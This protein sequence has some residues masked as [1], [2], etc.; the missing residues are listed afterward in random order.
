MPVDLTSFVVSEVRVSPI[1]AATTMPPLIVG[2]YTGLDEKE[3]LVFAEGTGSLGSVQFGYFVG[4]L[5]FDD[6]D[7]LWKYSGTP[8]GTGLTATGSSPLLDGVVVNFRAT[9]GEAGSPDLSDR[10]SVT[11]QSFA[12]G[13]ASP[14]DFVNPPILLRSENLVLR[15]NGAPMVLNEDYVLRIADG[16]ILFTSRMSETI[17]SAASAGIK[18]VKTSKD[19][20][21]R[22]NFIY[23]ESLVLKTLDVDYVFT[24]QGL[25][26]LIQIVVSEDLLGN[27]LLLNLETIPYEPLMV[28]KKNGITMRMGDEYIVNE[29]GGWINTSVPLFRG[30][31]LTATY[32]KEDLTLVVDDLIV[33]SPAWVLTQTGPFVF[34]T[35]DV[36]NF[37]V[38]GVTYSVNFP[39]DTYTAETLAVRIN[40]IAAIT[41]AT[42]QSDGTVKIYS[43][44]ANPNLSTLEILSGSANS[45]LGLTVGAY[46]GGVAFGGEDAHQSSVVPFILNTY[47]SVTG[48]TYI[49]FPGIDL[50]SDYGT[51]TLFSVDNDYYVS[52][53]GVPV[54]D[55]TKTRVSVTYS[56]VRDYKSPSSGFVSGVVLFIP[57]SSSY[58]NIP[59]S[60]NKVVFRGVDLTLRYKPNRFIKIGNIVFLVGGSSLVEGNTEVSLVVKT[61]EAIS[62]TAP[63]SYRK[64][65]V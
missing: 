63:V 31:V 15:K 20:I 7:S 47:N 41:V 60:S 50:T 12:A 65:V 26:E 58:E 53:P 13:N 28:V 59:V 54:Y 23:R 10:V 4:E 11:G 39:V 6:K 17:I 55:G 38:Q 62:N 29:L 64:S 14:L 48:Q 5:L 40:E 25:I 2:T 8:T 18:I 34:T 32:K 21:V 51:G 45:V 56:L 36:L 52:G 19:V 37:K 27:S 3:V 46:T 1:N 49:D 35:I 61:A 9:S 22:E 57:E 33:K 43:T 44:E 42:E 16:L 24:E 30:D